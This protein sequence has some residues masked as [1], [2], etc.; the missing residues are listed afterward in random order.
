VLR[1]SPATFYMH[2][3]GHGDPVKMATAR[4]KRSENLRRICCK[5]SA[6]DTKARR[7]GVANSINLSLTV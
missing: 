2:I 1:G 6:I 3:G 5:L 7:S 4:G